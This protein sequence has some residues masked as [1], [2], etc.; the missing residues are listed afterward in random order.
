[1]ER[2]ELAERAKQLTATGLASASRGLSKAAQAA[3]QT[4]AKL[5]PDT[6]ASGAASRTTGQGPGSPP[7]PEGPASQATRASAH[8]EPDMAALASKPVRELT[9]ELDGLSASQL[10]ELRGHEEAGKA[11][12]TILSAIDRQLAA[13]EG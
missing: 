11:R 6:E 10:R 7:A 5:R 4:A 2:Q 1:M 9:A 3:E 8:D 13:R 12:K